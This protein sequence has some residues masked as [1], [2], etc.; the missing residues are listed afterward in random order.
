MEVVGEAED[1]RTA[2][3]L[4]RELRADVVIMDLTMPGLNGVD[5][6]RQL[7][8]SRPGLRVLAL[9]MHSDKRFV[10]QMLRAGATGYLLKDCAY[11]ELAQAVRTVASGRVYL[12]PSV[13]GLVVDECIERWG[14]SR[15]DVLTPREREVVQLLAEG[16]P[17]KVVAAELGLSAKTVESHRKSIM[18]KLGIG[19]LAELTKY[20]VREGITSLDG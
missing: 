6:T 9:S 3:S 14:G 12:S 19:S 16:M 15:A 18:M 13:A 1:G 7:A 11:E 17:T 2:V 10:Q 4:A 5:A 20:A 8:A